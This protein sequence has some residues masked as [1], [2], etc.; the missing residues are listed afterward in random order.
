METGLHRRKK[1]SSGAMA[2]LNIPDL[3]KSRQDLPLPDSRIGSSEPNLTGTLYAHIRNKRNYSNS[4][5]S[6][7]KA[8]KK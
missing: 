3:A 8:I 2:N 1:F 6:N 5:Y 7:N 4:N